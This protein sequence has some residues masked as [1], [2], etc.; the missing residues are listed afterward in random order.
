MKLRSRSVWLIAACILIPATQVRAE[1]AYSP[2]DVDRV[3]A[4]SA[5]Q[6]S[7]DGSWIAYVV[8]SSNY[9]DNK[10]S[11]DV[12]LVPTDGSSG[13]IQ[14]TRSGAHNSFPKW[15]PESK[16]LGF[17]SDRDEKLGRQV[18]LLPAASAGEAERLTDFPGG[19]SEFVF[20]PDGKFIV[21]AARVYPDQPNPDTAAV[22]DSIEKEKKL[23]AVVHDNLL[24]R[25]WDAYW[26]KKVTHLFRQDLGG[27]EPVNLTAELQYDALNYWLGSAGREFDV[28]ADGRWVYFSGNQDADQAVSYNT[29][30][31][32]VPADGGVV[33]KLSD[34]LAADNHPRCSPDGSRLA[35]RATSRPYYESDQYDL[36]VK[37]LRSGAQTNLTKKFGRSVASFFWSAKGDTL[38]FSAED[39]GDID[40]FA[41]AA[42]GS[43]VRKV[44]GAKLG[45]GQGYHLNVQAPP[46]ERQF[47]FSHRPL[48][49]YYELACYERAPGRVRMLTG[50]NDSL[51]SQVYTPDGKDVYFEGTDGQKVHGMLFLPVDFDPEKKY[52]LLVRIH[53]GPQQMFGRAFRHEYALFAGAGYAVFACNPRG[54]TGYGQKFTDQIRGDWDGLVIEDIRA[55]VRSVLAANDFIDPEGVVGW[56]GSFGG[57]VCNWL[58]GHNEDGMF[59]TLVSH[60]GDADQWSAYG[61]TEELWFPEWEMHGPPWENPAM[62]DKVSPIRY[63]GKFNTPM[64]LTHGDLDYRVPITGSEQMFTA[65]QRQG[66]PSRLVRFPDEGHWILKPQNRRFWYEQ[67]LEWSDR[68]CKR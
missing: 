50:H 28:S 14:L 65:L 68:W 44:L 18:Y 52:P 55:G 11:S 40:L 3:R 12:F 41:V 2:E 19:V 67:I 9:E 54:S 10:S 43:E 45:G 62:Y 39:E 21:F 35:W 29:E 51:F 16:R 13:P 58:E 42:E 30:V 8:G 15:G 48:T 32:R 31:Y 59:A 17:I 20:G 27:G 47:Y 36:I 38:F 57:F 61:S 25:H 1:R 6:L 49:R 64:L 34:N 5:N 37:E 46:G 33:E 56:G 53:G 63:A 22:R 4:V 7:P 26:D 23:S 66:V 60:A 24:Y